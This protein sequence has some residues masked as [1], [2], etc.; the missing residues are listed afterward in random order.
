MIMKPQSKPK[1]LFLDILTDDRKIQGEIFEHVYGK[2][3]YSEAMRTATGIEKE[4]WY[5]CEGPFDSLPKNLDKFHGI[6]IGGSLKNPVYKHER[7]WMKKIYSF[8]QKA[9]KKEIPILGICGG[10]QFTAR[11]FGQEVVFNPR[12]REMGTVAITR[13]STGI[14]DPLFSGIS[15]EFFAQASH[16]CMVEK[17]SKG[18]KL[19][20]SSSLCK[21]QA[22]AAGNSV[23]LLQFHP[24][25]TV[26]QLRALAI[27]RK[28]HLISEGFVY[29]EKDFT[30]FIRGIKNTEKTGQKILG[31]FIEHFVSPHHKK[32]IGEK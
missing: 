6:I 3:S 4:N 21:T 31:N 29:D 8:I 1:I 32:Q 10:L 9:V 19:L 28:S 7:P 17:I 11:A 14:K 24:E 13:T 18:W 16:K 2:K 22:I 12:G 27:L 30:K 5:T 23:R 20:G 25:M 26:E 15:Q